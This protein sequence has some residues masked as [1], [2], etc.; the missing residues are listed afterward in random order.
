MALTQQYDVTWN[1]KFTRVQSHTGQSAVA[2]NESFAPGVP[3][4]LVEIRI[5]SDGAATTSEN[6]TL[7]LDSGAGAAWDQVYYSVDP[8]SSSFPIQHL[9]DARRWFGADDAIDIAFANTETNTISFELII[10][11]P[12]AK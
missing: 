2:V 1:E 10:R 6:F 4:Q 7:T 5:A 12:H 9:F 8:S 11:Y 3:F